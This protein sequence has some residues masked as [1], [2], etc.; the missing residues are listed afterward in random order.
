MNCLIMLDS[1]HKSKFNL[2]TKNYL[3]LERFFKINQEEIRTNIFQNFYKGESIKPF[4]KLLKI[5]YF[6][7]K[8]YGI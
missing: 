8:I 6:V 3:T 1:T 4:K 2:N 7:K 5:P